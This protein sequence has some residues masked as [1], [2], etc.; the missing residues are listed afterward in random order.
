MLAERKNIANFIQNMDSETMKET[1]K[2]AME[3]FNTLDKD[4]L[5]DTINEAVR[6]LDEDK[7]RLFIETTED[8]SDIIE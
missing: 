6:K 7:N 1:I 2:T 4:K 5:Q 8:I 3:V